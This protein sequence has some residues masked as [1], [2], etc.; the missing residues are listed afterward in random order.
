MP[1][2]EEL[3]ST[4][5]EQL[6]AEPGDEQEHAACEEREEIPRGLCIT[7]R[8]GRSV[9]SRALKSMLKNLDLI[10]RGMEHH[11]V[12]NPH[13]HSAGKEKGTGR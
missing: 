6:V 7:A 4:A 8:W 13:P 9:G 11:G 1:V 5:G 12:I 3:G 2:G 10:L